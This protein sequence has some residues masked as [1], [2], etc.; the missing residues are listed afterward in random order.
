M[1]SIGGGNIFL[2]GQR[3]LNINSRLLA[4]SLERLATGQRINR[5]SDDPAGLIASENLRA[6][7]AGLEAEAKAR[8]RSDHVAAVA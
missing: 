8:C 5:G 1:L 6:V 4:A 7:R 2:A 3:M